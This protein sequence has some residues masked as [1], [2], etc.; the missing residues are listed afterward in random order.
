MGVGACW[1]Q[2][3]GNGEA[4]TPEWLSPVAPYHQC[5]DS[6]GGA[7]HTLQHLQVRHGWAARANGFWVRTEAGQ[8]LGPWK[9]GY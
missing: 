4:V 6:V 5:S 8:R 7:T 1:S 2:D 3:R 9:R